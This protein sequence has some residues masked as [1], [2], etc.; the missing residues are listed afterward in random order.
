MFTYCL[1]NPVLLQDSEGDSP[2]LIWY[3]LFLN[4]EF[5]FIH[6]MVQ[7][8]IVKNNPQMLIEVWTNRSDG[9]LGR[10]DVVDPSTG[11]VWEVK[12]QNTVALADAQ[13][14]SYINGACFGSWDKTITDLGEAGRF[15]NV[16]YVNCLGRT[17]LVSYTT[18][19]P[20]VISYSV[21]ENMQFLPDTVAVYVPK[22]TQRRQAATYVGTA[23]VGAAIGIGLTG[24]GGLNRDIIK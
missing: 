2:A 23:F 6:R 14:R 5:G 3:F 20:G 9:T 13:A 17:Y 7:A 21:N 8:D 1:N 18:P 11:H 4:S 24:G 12:S 10:A 16:F 19:A 22:K 15:A